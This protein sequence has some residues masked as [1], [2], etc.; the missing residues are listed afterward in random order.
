MIIE[1]DTNQTVIGNGGNYSNTKREA[2][3]VF[4][5]QPSVNKSRKGLSVAKS[6]FRNSLKSKK[7]SECMNKKQSNSLENVKVS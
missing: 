3:E 4:C 1:N 7:R 6:F 2:V 5:Q